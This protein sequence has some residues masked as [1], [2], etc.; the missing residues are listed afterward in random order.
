MK[1]QDGLKIFSIAKS[2]AYSGM[3]KVDVVLFDIVLFQFLLF[4]VSESSFE[5]L[6]SHWTSLQSC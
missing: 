4:Q 5:E 6:L 1:I 3:E 2:E